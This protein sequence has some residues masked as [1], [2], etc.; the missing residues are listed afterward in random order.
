MNAERS[1]DR[2]GTSGTEA[3]FGFRKAYQP[4][5]SV[6]MMS[7]VFRAGERSALMWALYH[8]PRTTP[9]IRH[10]RFEP[11]VTSFGTQWPLQ[12]FERFTSRGFSQWLD[13]LGVRPSRAHWFVEFHRLRSLPA[14][15]R[16]LHLLGG[17]SKGAERQWFNLI[18]A[19]Q[20]RMWIA[21][22]AERRCKL[23]TPMQLA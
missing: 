5:Y 17:T 23:P 9:R 10:D 19:A 13:H 3:I 11:S 12:V 14:L 1:R 2:T 21:Q 20:S 4:T 6:H 22:A 7:R 8:F 15:Q 18:L 16:S